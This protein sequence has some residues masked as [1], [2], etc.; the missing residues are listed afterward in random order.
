MGKVFGLLVY[1]FVVS[2]TY[3]VHISRYT[4]H[5]YTYNTLVVFQMG[6][7]AK[8]SPKDSDH[9]FPEKKLDLYKLESKPVVLFQAATM[10]HLV[11]DIGGILVF[12]FKGRVVLSSIFNRY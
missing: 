12:Q 7:S 1:Q 8:P 3:I 4:K 5:V 9:E 11:V 6:S 10:C 2:V